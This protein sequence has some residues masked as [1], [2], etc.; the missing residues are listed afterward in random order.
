MHK[1][2]C[3]L[4][5]LG[6]PF[7]GKS[8]YDTILHPNKVNLLTVAIDYEDYSFSGASMNY[9]DGIGCTHD[10]LPVIVQYEA[11][12]DFGS[13]T[14]SL[15]PSQETFFNGTIVWMGLGQQQ[16]PVMSTNIT[17]PFNALT[18]SLNVPACMSYLDL[19]GTPMAG[20]F[21]TDMAWN[22]VSKLQIVQLFALQ[23]YDVLC[24]LYAPTV[25][26]FDPAPAKWL[27]FFYQNG[28]VTQVVENQMNEVVV[29]PNPS[30][31][32]LYLQ[33]TSSDDWDYTLSA[34]NG[35]Q[36]LSGH[37]AETTEVPVSDLAPG[38]YVI[39]FQNQSGKHFNKKWI[40]Q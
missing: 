28:Q 31:N 34:T 5:V 14:F 9:Y 17:P 20:N 11:P 27:F 37:L 26:F 39:E 38:V 33:Q 22:E 23:N 29:Y 4:F 32:A 2:F 3:Y 30:N 16:F 19:N 15:D 40:K 18:T 13:M 10:S 25:G 35:A 21:Q 7:F 36:I 6:I 8:Q 24:Y 1:L 12:M